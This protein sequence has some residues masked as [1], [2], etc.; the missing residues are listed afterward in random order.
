MTEKCAV[1]GLDGVSTEPLD[2]ETQGGYVMIAVQIGYPGSRISDIYIGNGLV[3]VNN[4]DLRR[5]HQS[6]NDLCD[7]EG[8]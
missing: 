5:A 8:G 3:Q 4:S 2:P 6:H 7:T 1:V